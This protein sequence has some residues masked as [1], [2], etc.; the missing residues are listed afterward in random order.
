M[1]NMYDSTFIATK[2]FHKYEAEQVQ[3]G[4][5]TQVQSVIL[6]NKLEKQGKN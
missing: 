2:L 5:I 6:S 4:K 1:F 3:C